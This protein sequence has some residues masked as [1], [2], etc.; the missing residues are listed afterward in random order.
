MLRSDYLRRQAETCVRLSQNCSSSAT[1]EELRLMA[2][3]F[4]SKAVEAESDGLA[5]TQR[6]GS[7]EGR[8]RR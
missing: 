3:E 6:A 4:F 1:A 7:D 8:Q 2:S 5:A